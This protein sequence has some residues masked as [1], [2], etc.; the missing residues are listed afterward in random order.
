MQTTSG[1]CLFVDELSGDFRANLNPIQVAK[2]DGSTGQLWDII[3]AGKH[4]NVPGTMLIVNTLV[5]HLHSR[6]YSLSDH[7]ARLKPA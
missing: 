2:C 4:N 7:A 6:N 3:T 5:S 1:Q